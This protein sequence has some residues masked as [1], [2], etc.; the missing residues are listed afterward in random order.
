MKEFWERLIFLIKRKFKTKNIM[1]FE[2][3]QGKDKQWYWR[4]KA[5]NGQVV[6]QG[7]GYTQRRAVLQGIQAVIRAIKYAE[8]KKVEK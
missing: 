2:Y 1:G 5:R 4:L 8:I 3:Y 7:E 6:A